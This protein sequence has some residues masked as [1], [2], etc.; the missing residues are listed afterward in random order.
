MLGPASRATATCFAG[1][2]SS[3]PV[4]SLLRLLRLFA[5]EL[6]SLTDPPNS[7]GPSH[8]A[9]CL[10]HPQPTGRSHGKRRRTGPGIG[11]G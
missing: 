6:R 8:E 10:V 5:A 7:S 3:Y 9:G 4:L 1:D 2:T 11:P